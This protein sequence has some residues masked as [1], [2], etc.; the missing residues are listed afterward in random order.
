VN[1]ILFIIKE[2]NELPK[3]LVFMKIQQLKKIYGVYYVLGPNLDKESKES[4]ALKIYILLFNK[5]L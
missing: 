5:S 4:F 1:L 3:D 2:S